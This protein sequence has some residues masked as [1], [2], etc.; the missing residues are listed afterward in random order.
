MASLSQLRQC[1][2]VR[3]ENRRVSSFAPVLVSDASSSPRPTPAAISTSEPSEATTSRS[4]CENMKDVTRVQWRVGREESGT[5]LDRFIKRRAPG[6]PPGLIQRLIRQRRISVAGVTAIRNAHPLRGG[7]VVEFPGEVKLGLSRGKKKPKDDDISLQEAEYIRSRV[8]HRDARCVVLDKPA[9]LATQGGTN[10]G[11]RHVEAFLPGLGSG[12]YWLVHRLDKDVSGALVVARD[13]GAAATLAGHFRSRRVQKT[14]WAL[15]EGSLKTRGGVIQMDI[16]GKASE[17]EYRVVQDL[18]GFGAWLAL[19][20]RTGRKHQL[21]IHCAEG[22]KCAIVGDTMYGKPAESFG[23]DMPFLSSPQN[24]ISDM[25]ESRH[26]H[27]HARG[28]AFPKL[29]SV[30]HRGPSRAKRTGGRVS[31]A[32]EMISVTA[33]LCDHMKG[34]WTR[35]GLVERLGDAIDW[36]QG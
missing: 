33:P 22:L 12:R 10:V 16:D 19:R 24:G 21:R 25:A 1:T 11:T 35:L 31:K 36:G 27:L 15:V 2:V 5:R 4:S 20:P 8:L 34:T 3:S 30:E 26:V 29:T 32:A 18:G 13:V 23:R 17:T 14:Y 9:G 7:E 28:I 6:V